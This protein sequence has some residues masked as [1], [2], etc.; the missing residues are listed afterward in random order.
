MTGPTIPVAQWA[1]E[2]KYRQEGEEYG[3]KVARVAQAL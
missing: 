2:Q 1:D 3:Q